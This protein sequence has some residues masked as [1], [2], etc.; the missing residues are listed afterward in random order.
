MADEEK[1]IPGSQGIDD[2]TAANASW[3]LN[4]VAARREV[5]LNAADIDG[6][7]AAIFQLQGSVFSLSSSISNLHV[8]NTEGSRAANVAAIEK[9]KQ[10]LEGAQLVQKGIRKVFLERLKNGDVR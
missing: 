4:G 9:A 2:E 6:L 1:P 10:S 8:G 3:M 5:T 7:L